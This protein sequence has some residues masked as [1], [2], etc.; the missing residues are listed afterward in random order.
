[1]QN[2]PT[3]QQQNRDGAGWALLEK[4]SFVEKCGKNFV[5]NR[6]VSYDNL[7]LAKHFSVHMCSIHSV[8]KIPLS[9]EHSRQTQRGLAIIMS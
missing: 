3:K 4:V 1:M 6:Y 8:W 2:K 5:F 7:Q 9:L